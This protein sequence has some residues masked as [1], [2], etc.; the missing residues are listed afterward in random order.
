MD[1]STVPLWLGVIVCLV[2]SGCF[3]ATESALSLVSRIRVKTW[4][5][6]GN[7]RASRVMRVL[8]RFEKALTTILVGNNI[9]NAALDNMS[10][11]TWR[12][13]GFDIDMDDIKQYIMVVEAEAITCKKRRLE[14]LEA[15]R[16]AENESVTVTIKED[17]I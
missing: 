10:L 9:V 4:A 14:A 17:E 16:Q 3:S 1:S 5:D 7:K 15:R 11:S 12:S 8:S 13:S 6:E 2:L